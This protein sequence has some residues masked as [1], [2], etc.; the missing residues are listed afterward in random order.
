M[1]LNIN[2]AWAALKE[3]DYEGA[4]KALFSGF[5]SVQE[6]VDDLIAYLRGVVGLE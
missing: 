4:I 3:G 2:E 1:K 6:F 5:Q